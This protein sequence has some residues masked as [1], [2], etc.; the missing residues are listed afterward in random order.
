MEI[1]QKFCIMMSLCFCMGEKEKHE[2]KQLP[3]LDMDLAQNISSTNTHTS[4]RQACAWTPTRAQTATSGSVGPGGRA[5][6]LLPSLQIHRVKDPVVKQK[7][8]R[9]QDHHRLKLRGCKLDH[10]AKAIVAVLV[11]TAAEM[12]DM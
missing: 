7:Q 11:E 10:V 5:I 1:N 3:V 6:M 8:D 9:G 12:C 2:S 4:V